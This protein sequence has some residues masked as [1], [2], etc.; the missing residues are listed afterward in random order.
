MST[1][2]S[3]E[4]P[5]IV[6]VDGSKKALGAARWAAAVA[7]RFGL[8]LKIVEAIPDVHYYFD[9]IAASDREAAIARLTASTRA[10]LEE[11]EAA[12]RTDF[13]KLP[14]EVTAVQALAEE[15]AR[16]TLVALTRQARLFVVG[17]DHV[18]PAG[19]LFVKSATLA[20]TAHSACPVVAW[21]G[22]RIAPDTRPVLLGLD[23]V[24]DA[25]TPLAFEFA[26]RFNAPLVAVHASSMRR[27][28]GDVTNPLLVDWDAIESDQ[29]RNLDN[30]LA[31]WRQR[32]PDVD[33]RTVVEAA[34]ASQLLVEQARDAQL[35]V[36][37][38]SKRA[39]VASVFLGSTNLN[40]LHHCPAP[41]AVCPQKYRHESAI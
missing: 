33:V 29:R 39:F 17:S 20:L 14:I 23:S 38:R 37:G 41:V 19:A 25:P 6:G 21:R 32:Y 15:P 30:A 13:S 22:D 5:V 18:S 16:D 27:L 34:D 36:V 24:D 1:A 3:R 35:V 4:W 12:V 2:D 26:H 40:L 31:Q 28:P 8:P 9:S 10:I 7:D 11:A